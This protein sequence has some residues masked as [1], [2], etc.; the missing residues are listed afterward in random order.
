MPDSVLQPAPVNTTT[1]CPSSRARSACISGRSG[2]LELTCSMAFKF[3]F[4]FASTYSYLAALRVE[5]IAVA[6]GIAVT[7]RPFL[8]GPIFKSQGLNDSPF[9]VYPVKGN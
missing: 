5:E 7:Y 4:E 8:L 3:W 9:N 1:R 6:R 2:S